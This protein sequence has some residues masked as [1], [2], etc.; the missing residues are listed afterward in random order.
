VLRKNKLPERVC[1]LALLAMSA[2]PSLA[3]RFKEGV[4]AYESGRYVEAAALWEDVASRENHIAAQFNLGLLYEQGL[5]VQ[6]QLG[7]AAHWY[8]LAAQQGYAPAQF[9]LGGMYN[10]GAGIPKNITEAVYWWAQAAQRGFT[11][12][13]FLLG[14]ILIKGEMVPQNVEDGTIWLQAAANKG[15]AK[16]QTLLEAMQKERAQAAIAATKP[17]TKTGTQRAAG[18]LSDVA[19][20]RRQAPGKYTVQLYVTKN[21]AAADEFIRRHGVETIATY[22]KGR[23]D[24]VVIGGVFDSQAA[25]TEAVAKL[26]EDVRRN[27]PSV[28][29]FRSVQSE[30]A[31]G[32]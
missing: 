15:H 10:R 7:K 22:Y 28:R 32:G 12:A 9:N 29:S 25:A 26:T 4:A 31:A 24:F 6:K 3:D 13:Q 2:A 23:T 1:A 21:A 30:L 16:A 27:N 20:I 17:P 8:R 18:V 5:G 14:L 11:D 19:W